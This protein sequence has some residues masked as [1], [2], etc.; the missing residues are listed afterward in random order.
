M[1]KLR[2]V[3]IVLLAV[4]VLGSISIFASEASEPQ[5]ITEGLLSTYFFRLEPDRDLHDEM[6]LALHGRP[7]QGRAADLEPRLIALNAR[8]LQHFLDEGYRF[9][10]SEAADDVTLVLQSTHFYARV[11]GAYWPVGF[12]T[13]WACADTGTIYPFAD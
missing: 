12:R 9:S 1:K 7:W 10:Y 6:S 4:F 13:W 2:L 11:D 5:E 8:S 3:V